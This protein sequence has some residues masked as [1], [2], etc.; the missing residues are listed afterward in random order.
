MVIF[1]SCVSLP[2]GKSPNHVWNYSESFN[3]IETKRIQ[4]SVSENSVP[5]N[6][7]VN[8]HYPY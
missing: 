7:M 3:S 5:L 4:M 2:E 1:H 8:D 6:P